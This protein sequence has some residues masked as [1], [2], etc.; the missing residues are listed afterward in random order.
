M[1]PLAGRVGT[2]ERPVPGYDH[3]VRRW[4]KINDEPYIERRGVRAKIVAHEVDAGESPEDVATNRDLPREPVD[5]A[6]HFFGR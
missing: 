5:A 1:F 3:L 4:D 6:V 2:F